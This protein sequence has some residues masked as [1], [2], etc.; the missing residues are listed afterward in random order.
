[1]QTKSF[2]NIHVGKNI[3][4]KLESNHNLNFMVSSFFNCKTTRDMTGKYALISNSEY[5]L[6]AKY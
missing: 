2:C 1:M 5:N 6:K 4:H 3:S